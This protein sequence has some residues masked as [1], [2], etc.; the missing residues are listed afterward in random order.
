M[1]A[2]INEPDSYSGRHALYSFFNPD[3]EAPAFK[4][5]TCTGAHIKTLSAVKKGYADIGAIDLLSWKIIKEFRPDLTS[6]VFIAGYGKPMPAPPLVTNG[7]DN[8]VCGELWWNAVSE[9]FAIPRISRIMRN[10]GI[11]GVT[12]L[13]KAVFHEFAQRHLRE[14]SSPTRLTQTT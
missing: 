14:S 6:S 11:S 10:V 2:A 9:A 8:G 5:E 7:P 12:R 13:E 1:T 3:F 4:A